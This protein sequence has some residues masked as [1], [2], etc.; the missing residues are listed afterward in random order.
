MCKIECVC[1]SAASEFVSTVV[2]DPGS[3]ARPC[4]VE[5]LLPLLDWAPV[6]EDLAAASVRAEA[7]E[8]DAEAYRRAATSER[9]TARSMAYQ[10]GHCQD[11]LAAAREAGFAV[12][13]GNRSRSK[14]SSTV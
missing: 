11:Q 6:L 12:L 5:I 2:P 9:S 8:M 3:A 13:R 4:R 1:A 7:D 10:L 14:R